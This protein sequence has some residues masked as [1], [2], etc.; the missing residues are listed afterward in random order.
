MSGVI[1]NNRLC[2]VAQASTTLALMTSDLWVRWNHKLI[3]E[4]FIT[5]KIA[6]TSSWDWF[7]FTLGFKILLK[8]ISSGRLWWDFASMLIFDF[9]CGE[10]CGCVWGQRTKKH[11]SHTFAL[12]HAATQGDCC[13]YVHNGQHHTEKLKMTKKKQTKEPW[14]CRRIER[15]REDLSGLCLVAFLSCIYLPQTWLGGPSGRSRMHLYRHYTTHLGKC[16]PDL[17]MSKCGW[18]N[19]VLMYPQL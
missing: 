10:N 17:T 7:H 11:K 4:Y 6:S 3:R 1:L 9:I 12:S 16:V 8:C 2:V 5:L 19:E 14:K 13:G 18:N 15:E